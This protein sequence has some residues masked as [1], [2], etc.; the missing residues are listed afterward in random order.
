MTRGTFDNIQANVRVKWEALG[1]P[2]TGIRGRTSTLQTSVKRKKTGLQ[3]VDERVNSAI[4]PVFASHIVEQ[5]P[6]YLSD[7]VDTI[8]QLATRKRTRWD[9]LQPLQTVTHS[10][11]KSL[12]AA[13]IFM[14][15]QPEA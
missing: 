2:N 14:F 15:L 6:L 5:H 1:H 7:V 13:I 8:G 3:A 4:P 10:L 9:M 11:Q 12:T